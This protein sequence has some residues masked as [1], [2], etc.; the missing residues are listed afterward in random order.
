MILYEPAFLVS[1]TSQPDPQ[2]LFWR[3]RLSIFAFEDE[4]KISFKIR[5][6]QMLLGLHPYQF[7]IRN[8]GSD[9]VRL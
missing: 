2:V 6:C 4:T 5:C 8:N 1:E 9:T 3:H 7:L